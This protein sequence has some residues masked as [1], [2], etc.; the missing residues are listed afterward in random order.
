MIYLQLFWG[1]TKVGL[2]GFGV[3]KRVR[4]YEV[5]VEGARDGFEVAVRI[6]PYLVAILVAVGMFRVW[7]R[8]LPPTINTMP[9]SP[10]V[11]AKVSTA[12]VRYPPR[13][14]GSTVVRHA[15]RGFAPRVAAVSRGWWPIWAKAA[16][17][18]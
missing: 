9:N 16:V 1:F 13:A 14:M 18:G 3:A 7:Y 12:A 2:L 11:W 4:I 17:K 15:S 6:I 10:M 5:F 8:I